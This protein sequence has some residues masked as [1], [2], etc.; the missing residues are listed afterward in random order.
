M[1]DYRGSPG[2][3]RKHSGGSIAAVPPPI[4]RKYRCG[5]NFATENLRLNIFDKTALL[6]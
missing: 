2:T 3:G 1:V 6:F 5:R 4:L